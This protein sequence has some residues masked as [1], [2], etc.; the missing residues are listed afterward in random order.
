MQPALLIYNPAA[1]RR[2]AERKLPRLLRVLALSGY[3]AEARATA[4]PGDAT[5]LA[6][7][8]A[9]ESIPA[10]FAM[11]GDGTVREVASGLRGSQ[12]TLGILPGGSTN[13]LA[14]ALRLPRDPLAA[15]RDVGSYQAVPFDVGLCGSEAFLMMASSGLDSRVLQRQHSPLKRI[16]GRTGVLLLGIS[17]WW[18]YAYPPLL[19]TAD[20]RPFSAPFVAV[21]NIPLYGG[22]FRLAPEARFDDGLLD[23]ILFRGR[24]RATTLGFARD[25][26]LG[27]HLSRRDVEASRARSVRLTLP[28]GACLQVD[29]DALPHLGEEVE[30]T[31][32]K[33]KLR[34]LSPAARPGSCK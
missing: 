14:R 1:G 30:L 22:P 31:I 13:V 18:R 17:E 29:G 33:E 21:C 32:S 11:G 15:A 27:R 25:L 9:C 23:L 19:G 12:T 28:A 4:G 8:A 6:R 20:G 24:G 34:I 2:L 16:L 3:Q 7:Q 10:V 26:A 5:V